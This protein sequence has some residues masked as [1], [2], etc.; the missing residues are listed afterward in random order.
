MDA[1]LVRAARA[2]SQS[3]FGRLVGLHQQG[4]RAF[5]RRTAGRDADD[6]AQEAFVTAWSNLARLKDD[7]GFRPW[8][9][10]IAWRK[11]LSGARSAG[12]SARRDGQW[13]ETRD[14]GGGPGVSTEDRMA[15][16]A[17]MATLPDDQRAAVALCLAEGWTH[18][19]AAE[20]LELPLGTIK[21]HVARGRGKLLAALGD[22]S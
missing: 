10:G 7:A 18:A 2:G 17:A 9:Y 5:L 19:E 13:L 11:A 6:V 15:L 4:L 8:L 1:P 21:S 14:Q 22:Q 16:E 3:A 12:R 20:A